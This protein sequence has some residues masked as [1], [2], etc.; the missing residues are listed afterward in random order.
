MS[1]ELESTH[2]LEHPAI[3]S[4]V[5]CPAANYIESSFSCG[6]SSDVRISLPSSALLL[7]FSS[8]SPQF[9]QWMKWLREPFPIT[10][11]STAKKDSLAGAHKIKL[12]MRSCEESL[13]AAGLGS[14]APHLPR[15]TASASFPSASPPWPTL[16]FSQTELSSPG[17]IVC[18]SR[19]LSPCY[20]PAF[21]S[22][23]VW[24]T[25]LHPLKLALS[26]ISSMKPF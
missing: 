4:S 11:C 13:W 21:G 20:R 5:L 3:L 18:A 24:Q 8:L 7:L 16:C 10:I 19:A 26:I 25:A 1:F 6:D 2:L 22:L 15:A 9:T 12:A 14:P 23:V 17:W